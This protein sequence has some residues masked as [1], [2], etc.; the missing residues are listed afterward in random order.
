MNKR[1][2]KKVAVIGSGIMGSG[3][4]CHFANIGVE[5][6][7]LDIVPRELTAAEKA[8]GLTLENKSVRNRLVNDSLKASLKSKPSPIYDQKFADR[9]STGNLEDDL[10]K[11]ADVDWVMEVV[12]ERLDIKQKVFEQVEKHRKP[13]TLIT[14]NTSGIPIQFMNKG[15]SEDFQQHFAVTHF[16]NPPRYLQLFEVVPGPDCKQEVTDFL[17]MYGE[18]FLGKTSVLAKDTPAFI[19]NRIGIFGIMS[20]FHQV[21]ELGLTVEEV[22]KLTG[23]V[24]GRPKSATFRTVDVVGLDTLVH[25]ANGIYE[26]CPKDKAHN[27]FK[28]PD[29]INKMMENN[30][31]GSKTGK[32]FY[33]KEGKEILTLDLDSLEYREKKRA[34]FATLEL[35]KTVDKVI[36]RF[37]ILVGG[38]DKAGEFYRKNFAAMFAY[39]QNRI[40]EISDELYRIDDAMKAGFGWEHGPFQIWDA[41][42][43]EK[44]I[45]L[46]KAEGHEPAKWVS[47][48]L[49]SGNTSFYSV[50]EGAKYYYDIPAKKQTKIPG[51]DAFIIIDNIREAKTVWKNSDASIQHL[52]NGVLNVEFQSKMNT[53]GSGV[54]QAINKGID[55]AET[56]YDAVILGNQDANFTVGANLAMMFM[57]A[58]EQEYDELNY[59]VKYFQDTVMRLRY[60]S[61]PTIVAPHGMTLGGGCELSLHADKVVAAAET[62]IGLVEFGVGIIPGGAGSKEMALRATEG[63][64]KDD[65]KLNKLRDYFINVAMAKVATSAYEAFDLGFFKEHKDIVVVN[66]NR[67]IATAKRHAIQ[68]LEDGYAQ[69]TPKK[70]YVMGQQALGMFLVGTDSL[71]K[72]HYASE[73][74]KKI[75]NKLGY[76][77]AG[78]DLS[79]PTYVSERYLLDLEREAFMSLTT[80]RKTLERIEHMLKTGKP[81]RN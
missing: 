47:E 29:F 11:I 50:K 20:L 34:K 2:I 25:V 38:K 55:L 23:P 28:L 7:L 75:A 69:P 52:G 43:V 44:G 62:Y 63:L 18:K 26:N 78:G 16:F 21:K 6:L 14:S 81:L 31:L 72:G 39:V 46:M 71:E 74:D 73:H 54:L 61:C 56:E 37:K 79:E 76:V 36:D 22:D 59:A 30:M 64:L 15:R 19:G 9:I 42:G 80:E 77:M 53:L 58:V 27:L 1:H 5:V 10:H 49:E 12:V 70:A 13:G 33:K 48:M 24:I 3:I 57:M 45:E 8:K 60:S 41:V 35:T 67:Q 17:M 65:V 40:P 51:Q 4:A 68:M 32:G 66:K